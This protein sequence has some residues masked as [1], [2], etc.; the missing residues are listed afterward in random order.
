MSLLDEIRAKARAQTKTIVFPE[1]DEPRTVQAAAIL[2]AQK[3]VCPVLLGDPERI[4]VAA[5]ENGADIS[6]IRIMDPADSPERQRYRDELYAIRK[7]KGISMEEADRLVSD[8]MYFGVM[9]VK[10]GDAD[11]L[12][13]GASHSTGDMLR[14]ALQ[15]IKT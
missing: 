12:V 4:H 13:S 14:P 7:R 15:I 11:G 5:E 1:G 6:G 2:Q 8:P 3:L 10:C 9:M